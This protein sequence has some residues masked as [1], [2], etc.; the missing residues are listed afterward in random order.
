MRAMGQTGRGC[1]VLL[2]IRPGSLRYPN[3]S[4]FKFVSKLEQGVVLSEMWDVTSTDS[5]RMTPRDLTATMPTLMRS[6]AKYLLRGLGWVLFVIAGLSFWAGG[7]AISEFGKVERILAEVLG[8]GIAIAC[9]VL[10][11]LA[12]AAGEHLGEQDESTPSQ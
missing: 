3:A 2:P 11:F 1:M 12:K 10:G 5:R 8:I 7:R 4:P 6:A 9:G